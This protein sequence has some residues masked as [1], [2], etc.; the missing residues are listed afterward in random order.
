MKSPLTCDVAVIGGGLVGVSLAYELVTSGADVVLIDRHHQGRATDAGAG[1]L[2][3]ET[4]FDDDDDWARLAFHAGE[5]HRLLAERV[6]EDSGSGTG[7]TVCGLMKISTAES[8]DDW[9]KHGAELSIRRNPDLVTMVGREEVEKA[10]PPVG[11]VSLALFNSAAARIDGRQATAAVLSAAKS[12]GL[13]TIDAEVTDLATNT[14]RVESVATTEETVA[15]GSVAIAGGAW[16]SAFA[17]QLRTQLPV[18]P[19][20]GQ[21]IHMA[22]PETDTSGWPILQPVMS[23]YLVPWPDGRVACGGTLEADAGFDTRPTAHG[24]HE[25]LREALKT[26]PGLA[27]ATIIETRVGLRPATSDGRPILGRLPGWS[28][29]YVA[30]G[31]GTEGLLLGPYTSALVAQEILSGEQN[32]E[33]SALSPERFL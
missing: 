28:N 14:E 11:H 6:A 21:I 9:L 16:T 33:L 24:V 19:L 32:A 29:A 26:A 5:H 10:F 8:E 30:T 25:L 2:A 27:P 13:R 17:D 3:P 7:R 23:H 12:R 18:G 4:F 1:I 20:K 31:H 15:A 22:L